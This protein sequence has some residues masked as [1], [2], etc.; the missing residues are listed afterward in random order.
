MEMER[1]HSSKQFPEVTCSFQVL[2][3]A[4]LRGSYDDPRIHHGNPRTVVRLYHL[5]A[6]NDD[7]ARFVFCYKSIDSDHPTPWSDASWL[8]IRHEVH[9]VGH[10]WGKCLFHDPDL[11]DP[12]EWGGNNRQTM[13]STLDSEWHFVRYNSQLA[14]Q[15]CSKACKP[16]CKCCT[17]LPC[18]PLCLSRGMW[19]LQ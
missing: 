10:I 9:Q 18:T 8:H 16:H 5:D 7:A 3:G 1:K 14:S 19:G 11:L 15:K 4:P 13:D 6:T 2:T 12:A 17:G